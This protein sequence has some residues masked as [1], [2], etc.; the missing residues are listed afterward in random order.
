MSDDEDESD[1]E[2]DDRTSDRRIA[3]D[4]EGLQEAVAVEMKAKGKHFVKYSVKDTPRPS[5]AKLV[6]PELV[7][8]K[9]FVRNLH[10]VQDNF[11]FTKSQVRKFAE[12]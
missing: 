3:Q 5:A 1:D 6:R 7:K 11:A 10:R 2:A 9:R 8:A 12:C 4:S